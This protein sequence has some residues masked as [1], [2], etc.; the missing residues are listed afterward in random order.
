M[1]IKIIEKI[2]F[3][4]KNI[5]KYLSLCVAVGIIG[6]GISQNVYANCFYDGENF[7]VGDDIAEVI[8]PIYRLYNQEVGA[9]L[10]ARGTNDA[11]KVL[12][13]WHSFRYDDVAP[14]FCMSL[15]QKE[16]LT[17][18]Y[19]LYNKRTKIHLYTK[20]VVDRDKILNKWH[21]FEF[22]DGAPAFWA[23]L[24]NDIGP[25]LYHYQGPN[26]TIGL[27]AYPKNVLKNT[28][29][30]IDAQRDYIIKD[31]DKSIIASVQAGEQTKVKYDSDGN[32]II[33]NSVDD[34]IVSNEVV[35]EA[36]DG[37][38]STMIF[39]I[40]KPESS[41]DE[42]RG[43]IKLRYDD[44]SNMIWVINELPL[45]QYI[46][47]MGEITGTGPMEYNKVMTTA[48][49]TYGYWKILYS[50][51]YAREG[52][53]VNATP[54]NQL[55]YGYEWEQTYPRIREGAE[56]T[57]GK[58]VK[59]E[60][61]VALTPYSSW[62]DGHTRSFEDRWGST[63]YPWCQSVN[64]SYGKHPTKSTQE[65][66]STGNHMVGIS[67][68]GALNLANEHGWDWERIMKHYLTNVII[69]SIY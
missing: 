11:N 52:F 5:N 68:H 24:T 2:I 36:V 61:D 16:G 60:D 15:S 31:K 25:E 44:D 43:K 39:D 48:Y 4:K 17:P 32:L 33:Y 40:H 42:Y 1:K 51:K 53:K 26:I 63:L 27:H 7:H 29:F 9:H 12:Q 30:K 49:R 66:F 64:D 69:T 37:I 3:I 46:W 47:G 50:T 58:I 13:K 41:F 21:D 23:H 6:F 22:T 54:G 57:R 10:Y 8:T 45:E 65:L 14:A 55:Y 38:D 19:R 59:H 35:F 18:I 62:T 34:I 28:S 20:G 67:A 56:A